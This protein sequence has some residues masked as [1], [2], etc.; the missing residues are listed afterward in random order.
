MNGNTS[1]KSQEMLSMLFAV[2][3]WIQ[4]YFKIGN[5]LCRIRED[6][7]THFD[8]KAIHISHHSCTIVLYLLTGYNNME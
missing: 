8:C 1:Y 7:N 2:S 6:F 5:V 4:Y 3:K